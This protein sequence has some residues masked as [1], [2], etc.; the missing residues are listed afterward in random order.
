MIRSLPVTVSSA[1]GV[2]LVSAAGRSVE[3]TC[4]GCGMYTIGPASFRRIP[5]LLSSIRQT[6]LVL[7]TVVERRERGLLTTIVEKQ[8]EAGQM[9]GPT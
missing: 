8:D 6:A 2:F 4:P 1:T 9:G 5:H 3:N 7:V